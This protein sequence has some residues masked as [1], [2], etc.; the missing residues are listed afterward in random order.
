MAYLRSYRHLRR[1]KQ[2]ANTL[3]KHGFSQLV[4]ILGLNSFLQN[5]HFPKATNETDNLST[6]KRLVKLLEELGP[7]FI[8]LGQILSTRID[9]LP[10]QYIEELEKLQDNTPNMT[11]K[12]VSQIFI[13][14]LGFNP[15]EVF[16]E[17]NWQPLASAS[18]G[19]V[20]WG[21]LVNGQ[22]VVVKVQ[23]LNIQ[24]L[25]EIDIEIMFNLTQFLIKKTDWAKQYSLLEM[26]E[27]ISNS[28]RGELDYLSE[29]RNCEK[30]RSFLAPKPNN[31]II[32][33]EV[34][35]EYT[36]G[37]V[38][39][40]EYIKSIKISNID[41]LR[42]NNWDLNKIAKTFVTSMVNQIFIHGFFHAD[43]HPGN[44]GVNNERIVFMDFGQVGKIDEWSRNNYITLIIGMI[45]QDTTLIINGLLE[46]G[47][48]NNQVDKRKLRKD[49]EKLKDKYYQL[50]FSQ[51]NITDAVT[52]I[53]KVVQDH[54]IK[55]PAEFG[56]MVKALITTEGIAQQLSPHLSIVE[57]AEPLGKE[58]LKNKYNYNKLSKNLILL[59]SDNLNAIINLP[60]QLNNLLN[61]LEDNKVKIKVEHNNIE[62]LLLILNIASNR[63]A[64]SIVLASII[65]GSSLT[66]QITN[67]W[68]VR[69][70]ISEFGFMI[71]LVLG[72]WLIFYIIKGGKY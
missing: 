12:E 45:K 26:V 47:V 35:W 29:G 55:V 52:E 72:L 5:N 10:K 9:L 48:V 11:T 42:K 2:I 37:K 58:I 38:L 40:L 24:K 65:I 59:I 19:Q 6:A 14:E 66:V 31:Q 57:V 44:I 56:I 34:Y 49:I 30:L 16:A 41:Q 43:P 4:S 69:L 22:E 20:H 18:I 7:T 71:A 25:M 1:Y 13:S 70:P 39:T 8:K 50:S 21:K 15:E 60:K 32:I 33:P 27:E 3:V 17:F 54:K 62:K 53:I 36:T 61:L 63:I 23:R 67:S 28:L 51:I 46:F 68:F 64:L